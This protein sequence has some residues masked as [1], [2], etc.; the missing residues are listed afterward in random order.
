MSEEI[1]P[2]PPS[3]PP[4]PRLPSDRSERIKSWGPVLAG[5]AAI[6]AALAT[7]QSGLVKAQTDLSPVRED[8]AALRAELRVRD[9]EALSLRRRVGELET[10]ESAARVERNTLQSKVV[11]LSTFHPIDP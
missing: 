2:P 10:G 6:V 4:P 3:I 8:V 9:E 7:L 1:R 5:I 11:Y